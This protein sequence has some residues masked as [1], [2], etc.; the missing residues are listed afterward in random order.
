MRAIYESPLATIVE[1]DNTDI[2]RCASG[3]EVPTDCSH[4]STINY[5]GASDWEFVS[6]VGNQLQ[7][8]SDST[9]QTILWPVW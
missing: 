5:L 2:V 1:I 4:A 3:P 6:K 8:Y 7:C 9:K